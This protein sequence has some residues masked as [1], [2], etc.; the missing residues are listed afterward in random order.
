MA[1]IIPGREEIKAVVGALQ[2]R[3]RPI[4]LTAI[5]TGLRASEPRGLRWADIDLKKNELHFRQ[6]ADRY[7][8]IGRPKS[9]L[10]ERTI[11]LPPIV[12]N[13]FRE[14]KLVCPKNDLDIVFASSRGRIQH[15]SNLVKYGLIPAQI[16]AGVTKPDGTAK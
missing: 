14:W 1:S 2:D 13:A 9:E 16:A 12:A 3:W 6:R 7:N 8:I 15:H 4:I 10:N 5:F 11:P